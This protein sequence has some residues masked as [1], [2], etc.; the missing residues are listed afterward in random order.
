MKAGERSEILMRHGLGLGI[1][2][3]K[4]FVGVQCHGASP[5][6]ESCRKDIKRKQS[7][8]QLLHHLSMFCLQFF[9]AFFKPPK[10]FCWQ[11]QGGGFMT[12]NFMGAKHVF[13]TLNVQGLVPSESNCRARIL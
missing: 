5:S 2:N 11:F 4:G 1:M 12:P 8:V 3:Q 7:V 10:S 13:M 9:A 6:H